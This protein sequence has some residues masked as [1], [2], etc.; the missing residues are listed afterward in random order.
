MPQIS[1]LCARQAPDLE[2]NPATSYRHFV[3]YGIPHAAVL[4]VLLKALVRP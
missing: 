1:E 3:F 2:M 4:S